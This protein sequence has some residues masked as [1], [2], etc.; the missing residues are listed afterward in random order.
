M[1]IS[2]NIS[3]KE[4]N[5]YYRYRKITKMQENFVNDL[6][7]FLLHFF[8]STSNIKEAEESELIS[9]QLFEFPPTLDKNFLY[10]SCLYTLLKAYKKIN[11]NKK[12]IIILANGIDKVNSLVKICSKI[13]Q[14]YYKKYLKEN[15]KNK[16]NPIKIVPFY[17]RKQLCFNYPILKTSNSFD[18]D[19]FCITLNKSSSDNYNKC[20]YYKNIIENKPIIPNDNM[21]NNNNEKNIPFECKD[22]D[23]QMNDMHY[24]ELCPFYLYM[25]KIIN[26]DY[27]IIICE[28]D[29]F[30]DN[31]KNISIRKMIDFDNMENINKYLLVFD[32]YNDIDDYLIK[33]YSCIIDEK[34]LN[35]SEIQLFKITKDINLYY[36]SKNDIINDKIIKKQ[37]ETEIILY[38]LF[39]DMKNYEFNGS[40][41]SKDSILSW[42][43]KLI[44]IFLDFLKNKKKVTTPYSP[45]KFKL[46]FY[47]KYYLDIT[48]LE[49][50]YKRLIILLNNID[51]FQYDKIYHLLHFIFFVCSL[52]KNNENFFVVN[53]FNI[54]SEKTISAGE[55]LLLKPNR[56]LESLRE[57]HYVLNLTGGMGEKGIVESYYNFYRMHQ[58]ED[59]NDLNIYYKTNLYFANNIN[60]TATE[61]NFYGEILKMLAM[62]V[63]DGIICYF[64]NNKILYEYI[65]KWTKYREQVFTH[66]L[67]YKLLFIEENDSER[68]ADIIVNYKKAINNGRGAILFLTLNNNKGKYLDSLIGKYSRCLIFIGFPDMNKL[69]NQTIY[70]LKRNYNKLE[71][72]DKTQIDNFE[73]FKLF[74]AKITNKID[75]RNDKTIIVI[76]ENKKSFLFNKKNIDYFPKWLKKMI[77]PEDDDERNNINE[78]IKTIP[79]FLSF[80][81]D[82]N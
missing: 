59:D 73:S 43:Q 55:F 56:I 50:I 46:E 13:N 63:P 35:F 42:L 27:D 23:L 1:E 61:T 10:L 38:N 74:A 66:V 32:E 26:K 7:K 58:Y 81:S 4:F 24:S 72:Y 64:G 62:N 25:N 57:S 22:I 79:E 17:N 33:T 30:F 41:K 76:L 9:R 3:E 11:S 37:P 36:N 49:Q 20:N 34:L 15:E 69:Y 39:Y 80:Y 77:S 2:V 78:K 51:Y 75:D 28:R 54:N 31:R 6:I 21:N 47:E 19:T 40:I 70:N 16:F 60:T 53:W 45:Y 5:V 29:Y 12:K 14:Y 8:N 82:I 67:N 48:I 18:M 52:A 44:V 65:E 71:R 68:L